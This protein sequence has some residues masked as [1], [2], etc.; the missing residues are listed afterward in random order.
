MNNVQV[1]FFA[2]LREKAGIKETQ[3]E[4]PIDSTVSEFKQFLLE[5]YPLLSTWV[6]FEELIGRL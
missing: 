6:N 5:K 4:I 3:F 1:F 2:T